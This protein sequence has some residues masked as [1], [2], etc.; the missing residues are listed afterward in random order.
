MENKKHV[1]IAGGGLSG[2]TLANLLDP[3][4]DVTLI[5]KRTHHFFT[6]GS[7]RAAVNEKWV[8]AVYIPYDKLL[9]NGKIIHDEIVEISPKEVKLK[10]SDKNLSFD[11]LVI[12]LGSKFSAPIFASDSKDQAKESMLN[13]I[14]KLQSAKKILVVGGGPV[15]IEYTGEILQVFPD[16][17]IILVHNK[18]TLLD[19]DVMNPK[20]SKKLMEKLQKRG[21][22]VILDDEVAKPETIPEGTHTYTTAK[23]V[24]IEADLIYFCFGS[25][26]AN[27][28]LKTHFQDKLEQGRIKVNEFLQVEGYSNIFAIGDIMN[29]KEMKL[30]FNTRKHASVVANNIEALVKGQK[31]KM[32]KYIPKPFGM[33]VPIGPNDG[34]TQLP[35][36]VIGGKLTKMLKSKHLFVPQQWNAF[37]Q[38]PP[39][40][41]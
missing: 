1:V 23:G 21:V 2:I 35:F 11:F 27:E 24:E 30:G 31:S 12:A 26:P 39:K 18:P 19:P 32:K 28:P 5:E 7:L 38:T 6:I 41:E 13:N 17:E 29:V 4:Y 3:K 9:K 40:L 34:A 10:N 37:H 15:G 20:L 8:D 33:V 36:G 14:K 16:K 22:R 25:A